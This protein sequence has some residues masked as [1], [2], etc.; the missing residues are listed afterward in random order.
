MK[1]FIL[2]YNPNYINYE[3]LLLVVDELRDVFGQA[4]IIKTISHHDKDA[5]PLYLINSEVKE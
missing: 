2:V 5:L 3:V 1:F 4:F